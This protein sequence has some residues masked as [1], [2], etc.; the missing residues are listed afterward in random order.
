MQSLLTRVL[1]KG[2]AIL[3]ASREARNSGQGF[4]THAARYGRCPELPEFARIGGGQIERRMERDGGHEESR[5][6]GLE[7][8]NSAEVAFVRFASDGR[9]QRALL[10]GE[11]QF[12]DRTL[13]GQKLLDARPRYIDQPVQLADAE[14][15][16]FRSGLHLD[17]LART[18][19]HHIHVHFGI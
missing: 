17:Q 11:F 6:S 9:L 10:H 14:R 7:T 18:G 5:K 4:H 16:A 8:R 15:F 13:H 1:F 19:H 2:P 12:Q 3:E